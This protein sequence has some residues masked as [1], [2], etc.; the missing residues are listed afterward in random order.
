MVPSDRTPSGEYSDESVAA[1]RIGQLEKKQDIAN[2]QNEKILGIL[3]EMNTQMALGNTRMDA[4]EKR[5]D[6]IE[7]DKRAV[8]GLYTSIIALLGTISTAVVG[9][10]SRHTPVLLAALFL[11]GCQVRAASPAQPLTPVEQ[12]QAAV[13]D[14]FN[15]LY[16]LA[17]LLLALAAF[18]AWEG[19]LKLAGLIAVGAGALIAACLTVTYVVTHAGLFL[20]LGGGL[21]AVCLICHFRAKVAGVEERILT[22]VSKAFAATKPPTTP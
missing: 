15:Y 9:F 16:V 7:A 20:L 2:A 1:Y 6:N 12:H 13:V 18:L 8:T 22:Q 21:G 3:G 17:V 4:S 10:F 14:Q 5:L 19:S 11:A